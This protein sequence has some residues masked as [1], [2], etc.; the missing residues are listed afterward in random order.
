MPGRARTARR[1]LNGLPL[2]SVPTIAAVS[3]AVAG[4]SRGRPAACIA[5]HLRCRLRCT[6]L[7]PALPTGRLRSRRC[8]RL[9]GSVLAALGSGFQRGLVGRA[10]SILQRRCGTAG[11]M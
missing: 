11:R 6:G 7:H 5:R 1:R 4:L 3:A 9:C 10:R 8:L 2:G